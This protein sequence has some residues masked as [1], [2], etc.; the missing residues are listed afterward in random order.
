MN[1]NFVSSSSGC[2]CRSG[3][4]NLDG[5]CISNKSHNQASPVVIIAVVLALLA[6]IVTVLSATTIVIRQRKIRINEEDNLI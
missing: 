4:I 2:S 1:G 5:K 3:Y 6:I